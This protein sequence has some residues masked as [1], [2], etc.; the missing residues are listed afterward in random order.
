MKIATS[1]LFTLYQG[2]DELGGFM[3]KVFIN[4]IVLFL[5]TN[6][7]AETKAHF[8]FT[9]EQVIITMSSQSF[10]GQTDPGPEQLFKDL[11][12]PTQKSFIG[13]GKVLKDTDGAM[14]FIVANRGGN[15]Y[16]VSIVLKKNHNIEINPITK[17][18]EVKFIGDTA[19]FLFSKWTVNS[20]DSQYEFANQEGNLRIVSNPSLFLLTFQ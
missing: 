7:F 9:G 4:L 18:A 8:T 19:K 13:D 2:D 5:A 20:S 3:F 6:S 1:L 16:D 14:T 15:R 11:N 12:L 17:V 10:L